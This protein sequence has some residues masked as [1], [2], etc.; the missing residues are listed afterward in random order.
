MELDGLPS[1]VM[2]WPWPLT[3][4]PNQYVPGPGTYLTQFLWNCCDLDLSPLIRKA[5]HHIYEQIH[6]WPKLGKILFV[7]LW[8]IVFTTFSGHC[9]MWPWPLTFWPQNLISTYTNQYTSVTKIGTHRLMHSHTDSPNTVCLRHRFSMVAER[10]KQLNEAIKPS[11][12]QFR[13][14]YNISLDLY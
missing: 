1:T 6:L 13:L 9:L 4:W 7:G 10:Q 8:D 2:L 12:H 14:L 11:R 3:F 5:N